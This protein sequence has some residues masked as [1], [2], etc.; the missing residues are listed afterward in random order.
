MTGDLFDRLQTALGSTYR[1][2]K[3]LGG[4]GMSRVF[5]AEETA[6]GRQVVIKVLPPDYAAMLSADRFRREIQLAS[7]LQHPHIVPLLTAGEAGGTLVLHH[8][9][10]RGGIAPGPAQPEGA[11]RHGGCRQDAGRSR[12]CAGLRAPAWRGAPRH[13]AGKHPAQRPARGGHRFRDREGARQRLGRRNAHLRRAIDGHSGV[14]G[15][16]ADRRRS[17]HRPSRRPLRLRRVGLRN[18]DREGAV[19]RPDPAGAA[20]GASHRKTG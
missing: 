11:N 14:H 1:L 4:G 3:E 17:Q 2:E 18:A 10:R 8:A 13:Q 7:R 15:A 12:R 16:G 19:R 6:L 5:V 9:L 20:G